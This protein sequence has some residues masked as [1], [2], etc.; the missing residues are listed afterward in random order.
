MKQK[1]SISVFHYTD[2]R[3]YLTDFYENEKKANP[4]FSYR[5]FAQRAGINSSGL[6]MDVASGRRPLNTG[7]ILKFAKALGLNR[8][9]EEYFENAVHFG[10]ASGLEE[11]K[12]F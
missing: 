1:I 4:S 8:K 9:E 11:K 2:F 7:Q 12:R 3:R 5:A 10:Q 6:Y